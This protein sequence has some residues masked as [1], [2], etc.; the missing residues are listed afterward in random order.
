MTNLYDDLWDD[1]YG[2]PDLTAEVTLYCPRCGVDAPCTTPS[3]EARLLLQRIY[4]EK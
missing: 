1:F 4:I 2:F 3:H